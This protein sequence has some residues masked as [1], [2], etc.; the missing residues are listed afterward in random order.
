[1]QRIKIVGG[2]SG[3]LSSFPSPLSAK[4]PQRGR[5]FYRIFL[6]F[7]LM[8]ELSQAETRPE[9]PPREQVDLGMVI[10]GGVSLGAY[11]A[12][13]NWA[14][15]R[16]LSRMREADVPVHP[17]LRD[18]AGVSALSEI[19]NGSSG[20]RKAPTDSTPMWS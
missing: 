19:S 6:A 8:V 5:M 4:I 15:I 12:G 11:E 17:E 9:S 14:L 18:V 2:Y 3:T 20:I 13:Y 7:L 1:L 16:M 10:S